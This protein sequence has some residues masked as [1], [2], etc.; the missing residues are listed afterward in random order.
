MP[1]QTKPCWNILSTS[2]FSTPS[3]IGHSQTADNFDSFLNDLKLNLDAI[4]DNN[5]FLVAAINDFNTRPSSWCIND[6]SNY[7]RTKI[8]YLATEYDLKQV[9]N[10]LTHLLQ[11]SSSCIDLIFT[12]Q[13][14]LVMDAGICPS[15]LPFCHAKRKFNI[16]HLMKK[17]FGLFKNL[18]SFLLEKRWTNLIGKGLFSILI[19]MRW[20]QFVMQLLRK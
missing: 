17:R 9:I 3:K 7:E 19:S 10:K 16:P 15:F 18:T 20:Y 2:C 4:T 1:S 5:P 11:N 8:D 14:S 6:K 13:A 12:S